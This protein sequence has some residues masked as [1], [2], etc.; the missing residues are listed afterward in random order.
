VDKY[1]GNVDKSLHKSITLKGEEELLNLS[2][3]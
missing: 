1:V 2:Q 3:N